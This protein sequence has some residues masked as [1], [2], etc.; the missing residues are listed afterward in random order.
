MTDIL[1]I[2]ASACLKNSTT[3]N[4]TSLL[5]KSLIEQGH[6][7]HV[8]ERDLGKSQP[9]QITDEWVGASFTDSGV[10]SDAQNVLLAASDQMIAELDAANIIVIGFPIYNF[11]IPASLKAWIDQVVRPGR[12]FRYTTDGPEGLVRGK[13]AYFAVASGGVPLGGKTD[14]ATPYMRAIF[15]FMGM[16]D[17][18]I[19]AAD[20]QAIEGEAIRRASFFVSNIPP[21]ER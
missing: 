1:R 17:I 12:T 16:N 6:G 15:G 9:E 2:D 21:V 5:V 20:E 19:L 8:R 14:F 18:T 7:S 3:R 11:S 10:R 4:L 13:K